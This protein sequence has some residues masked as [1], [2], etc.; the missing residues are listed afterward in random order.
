MKKKDL[1][2]ALIVTFIWGFNFTMIK[3]A[4]TEVNP[5]IMTAA[6]F[7]L[8]VFPVI[9]FIARPQVAWRYLVS[10]GVVF[11]VGIWGMAS[12]SITMGLS[13][14]M[15]SVL[16]QSSVLFGVVS[17]LVLYKDKIHLFKTIGVCLAMI[18]LVVSVMYTNGNVTFPGLFL[19]SIAASSWTLMG[20][21]V[22]AAKAKRA[23]AFNV[24]GMLFAPLPLVVLAMAIHGTDVIS[25]SVANW[26]WNTTVAVLFQ[27]YPTT[28]FGYWI[29]N[30]LVLEYPMSTVAPLTLLVPVFALICGYWFY[31]ETLSQVQMVACGLFLC[32]IGFIVRQPAAPVRKVARSA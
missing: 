15:S 16:M 32:G 8:A 28:L 6:R 29:W 2:L 1:L 30:R 5:L 13:S 14:G 20:I 22:K 27:A 9:F 19:I 12:W 26:D 3:L 31:D 21:I 23:F 4:V 17:G 11:G 25:S 18:G 7:S 24:W 10:Y